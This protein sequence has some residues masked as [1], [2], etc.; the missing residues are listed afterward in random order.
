MNVKKLTGI[1][2]ATAAAGLFATAT[3]PAFAA[4]HEGNVMCQGVNGCK[5]KGD[6]ATATNACKGQ[7]SCKGKGIVMMSAKDCKA[8]DGKYEMKKMGT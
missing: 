3:V 4:K 1:A 7:N 6:C 5:G 8:K 2:L